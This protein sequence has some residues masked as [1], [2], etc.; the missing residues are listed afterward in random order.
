MSCL[1]GLFP[2]RATVFLYG[3]INFEPSIPI[4]YDDFIWFNCDY[5]IRLRLFG[6]MCLF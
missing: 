3:V 2:W 4:F 6:S 5:M 1:F